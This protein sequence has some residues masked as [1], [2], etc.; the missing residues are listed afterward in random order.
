MLLS[1]YEVPKN[2]QRVEGRG[3]AARGPGTLLPGLRG[4][5][6]PRMLEALLD[7]ERSVSEL[8]EITR[9]PQSRVSNHL[10]CLKWCGLVESEPRGRQVIYRIV[11]PQVPQLLEIAG[12]LSSDQC[13]HLANCRRIGPD[14][15]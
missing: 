10:A 6:P 11:D 12:G 8:M 4:P 7:R 2:S 5:D 14:W 15:I 9:A 3:E 13:D 1:P